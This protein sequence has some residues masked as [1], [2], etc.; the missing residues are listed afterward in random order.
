[1]ISQLRQHQSPVGAAFPAPL[2]SGGS[3]CLP[4][5]TALQAWPSQLPLCPCPPS[6]PQLEGAPAWLTSVLVPSTHNSSQP[7]G[8]HLAVPLPA[9][10]L[11]IL[12]GLAP[13]DK[14]SAQM[15]PPQKG[16]PQPATSCL[17]TPAPTLASPPSPLPSPIL[18]RGHHHLI[19][20]CMHLFAFLASGFGCLPPE[21][22]SVGVEQG[23][24]CTVYS[25]TQPRL[26]VWHIELSLNE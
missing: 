18:H 13:G 24:V 9:M 2:P 25:V 17:P 20:L 26:C 1:M 21:G 7:Q 10:F 11:P 8:L 4:G 23:L 12:S 15:S 3:Q 5:L 22:S 19:F 16:L 14:I 6:F